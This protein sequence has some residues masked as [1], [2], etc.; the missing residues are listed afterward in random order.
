[1]ERERERNKIVD[2][3]MDNSAC[4]QLGLNHF[5]LVMIISQPSEGTRRSRKSLQVLGMN[6]LCKKTKKTPFLG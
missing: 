3:I 2:Y 1:M 6:Y 4:L 5:I